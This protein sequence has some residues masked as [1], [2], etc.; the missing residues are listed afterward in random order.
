MSTKGQFE[1]PE[2][3]REIAERNVDQAR[4]A[5]DQFAQMAQ[6][7]Q[8]MA[9]SS[10]GVMNNA[11]QEIQSKALDYARE[12]ME[13]GFTLASQ[14]AKASDLKEY[15]EIQTGFAQQQMKAYGEQAQELGR[16]IGQAAQ[17]TKPK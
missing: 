6:K 12:N 8:D 11:T 3:M 2:P 14:L 13:S 10:N 15:F 1:I 16:L 17:N 4:N 5:Y 9:S 7:A